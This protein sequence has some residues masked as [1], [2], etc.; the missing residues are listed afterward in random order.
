MTT[1]ENPFG[2]VI[3]C[4]AGGAAAADGRENS[5]KENCKDDEFYYYYD[6]SAIISHRVVVGKADND[7]L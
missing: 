3:H 7:L 6:L 2:E 4:I 1:K 5:D